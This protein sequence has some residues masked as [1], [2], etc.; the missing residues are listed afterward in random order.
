MLTN[1]SKQISQDDKIDAG[2]I[3]EMAHKL[4]KREK[5]RILHMVQYAVLLEEAKKTLKSERL[6]N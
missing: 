6:E 3:A 4:P 1:E 5:E 2:K